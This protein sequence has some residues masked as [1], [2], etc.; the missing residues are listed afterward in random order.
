MSGMPHSFVVMP[1]FEV[2]RERLE[3]FLMAAREDA[4]ASL[5]REPDCLQFDI[6]V[7]TQ[8]RDNTVTVDFYEVYVSREAF[9]Q[10]LQMPHLM[11]FREALGLIE[12]EGPVRFMTRVHAGSAL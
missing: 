5:S 10:H 1:T 4:E 12:H 6:S 2:S 9:E 3:A 8:S 7:D 11:R